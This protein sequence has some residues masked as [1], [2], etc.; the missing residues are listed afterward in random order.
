[1]LLRLALLTLC[2]LSTFAAD[3]TGKW[4][5]SLKASSPDGDTEHTLTLDLKQSGDRLTGTAVSDEG[6]RIPLQGNIEGA[7]VVLHFDTPKPSARFVLQL[8]GLRL[9]GEL[10]GDGEDMKTKVDV[11]R[12]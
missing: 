10:T 1:M 8:D 3:L 4:T 9:K 2:A 6:N 12:K 5:G 7:R 11:V